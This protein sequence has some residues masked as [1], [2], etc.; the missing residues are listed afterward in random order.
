MRQERVKLLRGTLLEADG[1]EVLNRGCTGAQLQ[2]DAC[3]RRPTM[4]L[5][6]LI[7]W[8]PIVQT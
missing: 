1:Y 6:P 3:L 4:H 8:I 5:L 7:Q 2:D